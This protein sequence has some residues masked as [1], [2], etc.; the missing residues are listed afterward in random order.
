MNANSNS[1]TVSWY[2]DP[3]LQILLDTGLVLTTPVLSNTTSYYAQSVF[4]FGSSFGGE[5]DNTFGNGGYFNGNQHLIFDS[6]SNLVIKSAVFYA[7]NPNTITFELRD[8]NGNVLDDTTHNVVQGQQQ[9]QLNFEVPIGNDLQLG[10]S[11]GNSGL[12]RNSNGA[13]YPYNIG[14]MMSITGSSATSSS[15]YYYFYYDIEIEKPAC[16]SNIVEV[17]AKV[18]TITQNTSSIVSCGSYLWPID[19]NVYSSSE[20]TL[21]QF[22]LLLGV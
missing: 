3:T 22:C 13:S 9:L 8:N 15:G 18:D 11:N 2:S 4:E 5:P 7:D 12:Y 20:F 16:K 19:S 17:V 14:A 1:G 6:Y 21:I 10:I